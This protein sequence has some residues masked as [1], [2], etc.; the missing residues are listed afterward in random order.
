MSPA[1]RPAVLVFAGHDPSG[2][3]GL[4]ADIQA[5]A[6]H[7]THAAGIVT[8]LTVQNTRRLEHSEPVAAELVRAQARCVLEDSHFHAIKTGL[9]PTCETVHVVAELAGP[10]R[11]PLVLDPVQATDA[12]ES[13][14]AEGP[15]L[16]ECLRAELVPLAVLVTPNFPEARWL[17][18]Q[19]DADHQA[20]ELARMGAG[21]ILIKGTHQP[22]ETIVHR[23]YRGG[24]LLRCFSESRL[25]GRFHGSGCA[26]ASAIA[27]GLAR[28]DDL[29]T[30]VAGGLAYSRA[31]LE[32][33]YRAGR[34]QWIPER[35]V[36]G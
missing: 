24:T 15:R 31:S 11:L 12:G 22:G 35:V 17:T 30:A 19:D 4:I 20:R 5:L 8:A 9:L 27:A 1:P 7:G 36:P 25:A 6:A 2:G 26:L 10:L 28:G 34:D 32:R 18:G 16:R 23:L 14:V 3:A 13:L 21:H 33:A 29:E